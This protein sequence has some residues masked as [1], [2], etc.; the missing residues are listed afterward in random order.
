M[1]N[2]IILVIVCASFLFLNNATCKDGRTVVQVQ[3][4]TLVRVAPLKTVKIG[5]QIWTTE[6]L[7]IPMPKSWYYDKDSANNKKYG[8]LYFW[9]NAMACVPKGWHIPSLEEWKELINL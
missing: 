7:G 8:R 2:R 5:N 9:S 6:N 4:A 3:G 1:K